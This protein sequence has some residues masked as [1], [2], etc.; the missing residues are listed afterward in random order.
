MEYQ[1]YPS[2]ILQ[3]D[4]KYMEDL[5]KTLKRNIKKESDDFTKIEQLKK[6][7]DYGK[8]ISNRMTRKCKDCTKTRQIRKAN[9]KV[10]SGIHLEKIV[11]SR[12]PK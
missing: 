3:V 4:I 10:V 1:Q 8:R 6:I 5:L 9:K 2:H 11:R 7:I 12:R